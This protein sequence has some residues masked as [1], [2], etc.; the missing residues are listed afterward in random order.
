[1]SRHHDR[2]EF[3]KRSAQLSAGLGLLGAFAPPASAAEKE[4]LFR[5]SLAEWSLHRAL[6]G[7]KLDNLDFAKTAKQ[8]YGIEAVEYVNQFFKD[9]AKDQKYLAEMKKRAADLGVKSLL[10]MI[11]GE[12]ALGDADEKKRLA[13]VEKH[14]P[15]VEAAKYLGCHAI[16]VNAASSGSYDEQLERAA[17]GLRRLSEFGDQHEIE[18]IVENHGGLSSNG[19]WLAAVIK[20]VGHKRCGTLPDFGNFR[21]AERKYYDRY[22]GVAELMPYAKAVSAKSHDFNEQGEETE[23]DYRKM[24]KIVLDAGYHGYVGIEYEGSQ[25][26]EPEGIKATKKLLEKVRAE[27]SA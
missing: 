18:V 13:A 22:K 26:S 23:T 14:Y 19:Q 20:K 25:L 27:L 21:L 5:I 24:M 8:D 9:K 10:I 2:R 11:D 12:G 17:D 1:M 4:P 6:K 16:R 7:G 3:L 15:W